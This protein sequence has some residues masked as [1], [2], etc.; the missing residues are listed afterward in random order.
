MKIG[1]YNP[2]F[3]TFGG[4]ERYMLTLGEHWSKTHDVSIFWDDATIIDTSQERFQL[5]LS[6]VEVVPNVFKNGSLIKKM[7]VS[8]SYDCIVF[9]S[10]GSV[11]MTLAKKNILHFQVPFSKILMNVWKKTRY[12]YVVCNSVFTKNHLDSSLGIP[13]TV[14]YPPVAYDKFHGG[15]KENLIVSVGRFNGH[16]NVKKQDILIGVFIDMLKAKKLPG[17]RLVLAGGMLPTD[18][19]YVDGLKKTIKNLP[20]DIIPNATFTKIR[21]LYAK[22]RLY[23]HAAGF[24]ETQ[25]EYMEHFGISTVEAMASGCIPVVFAGGGQTEIV[26]DGVNGYTWKTKKEL[27]DKTMIAIKEGSMLHEKITRR[28]K[29]FSKDVFNHA[30]DTLLKSL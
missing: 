18:K 30:F 7:M 13:T 12:Q 21:S 11:P 27:I 8:A 29:D 4:G 5:D 24:G 26:T 6:H 16:Y 23:W 17:W 28:A 22:A 3:D 2:Y 9:L 14:I 25:P 10:D 1:I 15:K 19:Q 20:I